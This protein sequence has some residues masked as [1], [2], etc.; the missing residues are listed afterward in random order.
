MNYLYK[1]KSYH[2]K[3]NKAYIKRTHY[4]TDTFIKVIFNKYYFMLSQVI[5]HLTKPKVCNLLI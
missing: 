1:I 5:Y 2:I 3:N 4:N